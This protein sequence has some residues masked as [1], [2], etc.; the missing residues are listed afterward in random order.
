MTDDF[1]LRQALT[2]PTLAA[3]VDGRPF[4]QVHRWAQGGSAQDAVTEYV[5]AAVTIIAMPLT[6]SIADGIAFGFIAYA[7]L[8]LLTGK[9]RTV[10][11]M[12]RI[13]AA[14]FIFKFY[15]LPGH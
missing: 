1:T 12:V 7:V 11:V 8:E 14:V 13:I 6:F 2:Y 9:A 10:P 3:A 15:Y 5:P 4:R